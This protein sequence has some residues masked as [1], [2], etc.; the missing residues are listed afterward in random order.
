MPAEHNPGEPDFG[1]EEDAEHNPGEPTFGDEEAPSGEADQAADDVTR[2]QQ[3]IPD[4]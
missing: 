4:A 2:E 3:D 1:H